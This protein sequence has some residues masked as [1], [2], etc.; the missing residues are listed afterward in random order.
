M[1]INSL[2]DEFVKWL[3]IEIKLM[4]LSQLLDFFF[5]QFN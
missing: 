3:M 5:E 1:L 2:V 4:K